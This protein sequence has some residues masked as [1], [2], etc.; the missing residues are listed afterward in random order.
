MDR[1]EDFAIV[2]RQEY[3]IL[4][5]EQLKTLHFSKEEVH[6]M[7]IFLIGLNLQRRYLSRTVKAKTTASSSSIDSSMTAKMRKRAYAI[8]R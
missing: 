5:R 6:E 1:K 7:E 8:C 3:E 2:D 4:F